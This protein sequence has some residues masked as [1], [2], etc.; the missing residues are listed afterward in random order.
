[1]S[2]S[3]PSAHYGSRGRRHAHADSGVRPV[4]GT[5]GRP[6][7]HTFSEKSSGQI[8]VESDAERLVAQM[9][10]LDPNVKHFLPQ[11]FTVDLI[12]GLVHK[13]K[14]A[15]QHARARYKDFGGHKFYTPDF[16]VSRFNSADQ[17]LEVKLESFLG[18]DGYLEKIDKAQGILR[19]Y[20]YTF[21]RVVIPAD[22]TLPWRN[23]VPLLRQAL[24][25]LDMRSTEHQIAAIEKLCD[26]GASVH[27][28][29]NSLNLS[30]HL[31][32]VWLTAG[33]VAADLMQPIRGDLLLTSA[34]GDL[35]HLALLQEFYA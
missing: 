1:M 23:N 14:D 13:T 21:N 2:F 5:F 29:C 3:K 20:G 18:D 22:P 11:P 31:V 35:S 17:V 12:E 27:T 10:G 16:F 34:Y 32:P 6:Q 4:A 28:V 24:P 33:V 9:L 25:R 8:A 30:P 26:S 15:V 19:A 7:F